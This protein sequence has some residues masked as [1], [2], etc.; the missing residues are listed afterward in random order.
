[1]QSVLLE[2]KCILVHSDTQLRKNQFNVYGTCVVTVQ[3]KTGTAKITITLKS[4]KSKTIVVKVQSTAVKTKK[5]TGIPSSI[6]IQ[7]GKKITLNPITS[8]EK[9][10]YTS[11]NKKIVDVTA[12]GK[13]TGKATIIVKSGSIVVK[14]NVTVK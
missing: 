12:K 9:I 5:I 6:T 4:G 3:K 13:V 10:S 1:M 7:K 14:C 8:T 11:S 2:N